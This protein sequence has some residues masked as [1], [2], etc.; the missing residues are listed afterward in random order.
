MGG[1]GLGEVGRQMSWGLAVR[2]PRARRA[3][4]VVGHSSRSPLAATALPRN[5][6]PLVRTCPAETPSRRA[7]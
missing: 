7:R 5:L 2:R 6:R 1:H 4:T 3:R